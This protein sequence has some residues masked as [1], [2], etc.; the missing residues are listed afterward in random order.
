MYERDDL[1]VVNIGTSAQPFAQYTPA[2]VA[3]AADRRP[4]WW[5]AQRLLQ[6]L[7]LP[8][9]LDDD[10]PDP[11]AK[12][13]HMLARGS[14][15]DLAEL[16]ATGDVRVLPRPTP[17]QFFTHQ[18]YTD[19]ARVDCCPSTFAEAIERCHALFDERT[20]E[21]SAG[22]LLI[23]KRDPWMHNTWFSN[24]ARMKRSGRTSNPL[25]MH[26]D[27]AASLGLADG[28]AVRVTSDHGEIASVV[29]HDDDL[30]PGVVSMVHGWGHDASP[31]LRIAHAHPGYN[32][33]AL[34]PIGE[35]SFE[36]L[37][38]QAHMTGIPVTVTALR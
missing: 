38:S 14:G 28:D 20:G 9:I 10:E 4:E 30:M 16:Q 6:D 29:E 8:S 11:W 5:I 27:D 18:I 12:W 22:L 19:D 7:S 33:N 37:S 35:G 15:I 26:P 17:G 23:H 24:V 2:V 1:N 36:P 34:L 21:A 25:G 3:P 31:G 32:P 13:R